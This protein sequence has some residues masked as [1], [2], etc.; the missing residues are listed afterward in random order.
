[1]QKMCIKMISWILPGMLLLNGCS[2]NGNLPDKAESYEETSQE[3][4]QEGTQQKGTP[5][6]GALPF[7]MNVDAETF[8]LSFLVEDQTVPISISAPGNASN[9]VSNSAPGNDS[10]ST[11]GAAPNRRVED[12]TEQEGVVS[13]RYPDE[14]IQVQLASKD[15]YLEVQITSEKSSDNT[16]VWPYI[17]ADQ[18]YLPLG[19]GKRV[20][21]DDPVWLNYLEQQQLSV[22]EQFSMPFW[23]TAQGEYCVLFIMEDP[24]RTDISFSAQPDLTFSVSHEYPAIDDNKTNTYRIY[25]TDQNPVSGA[26]I[27]R[28][29]VKE[30]G[31]FVTLK[32]KAEQNS[33]IE[34]LYGAPF[35]YLWGEFVISDDDVNWTAFR[36]AIDTPMMEYLRSFAADVENG[37]EFDSTL[38]ELKNQDYVAVYQ[39]NV[40]CSYISQVLQRDDFWNPDVFSASS[41]E[42]EELL[43][44]GYNS[45]NE[46]QKLQLHKYAL[47]SG[48]PDVFH[49]ASDWMNS[50]TLDLL[51][52]MQQAGIEHAWIGLN[53]WEQ[54]Y[55]KPELVEQ[56][57][58]AGYLIASYDS[59]HSIHAPGEEQWI[60]ARFEEP[61]LYENA[62]VTDKNGEKESGFQNVGR[63]LNP[64]LSMPSVKER[65][66]KIMS[67]QLPFNSWFIDCDATGEIYDDYTPEHITTQEQDLAARLERMAYIRDRYN[68]II[69]SEGGNDFASS[70]IAFA[71]GIE[72]K[73]FSWMDADMKSNKDSEYYIGKYYNPAGGAA[74]HFAKRI[75][76]KPQY[77]DV[78]VDPRY[79][80]PLFK[81]VYNDSVITAAHW[82]WS[83]FKIKGAT[84]D[85]MLREVLYN[86]PPIYHL[87]REM[88]S[89]YGQDMVSHHKVWSEFSRKAIQNEMTDFAYLRE[90]GTVQ[91]TVY[92][93]ELIAVANFGDDSFLYEGNEIAPHS[94]LIGES[95]KYTVYTPSLDEAHQ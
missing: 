83:T 42:M 91:K 47:S 73:S 22:M 68:L 8:E 54:A 84:Q 72:L 18:Y 14:H 7:T 36:Q 48:M 11:S 12:Y 58:D 75:P 59:Y 43:S 81:L 26:A 5:Q 49:E 13:W 16:F 6:K 74:E 24:Y 71:H 88:W 61:G 87:D 51:S 19:E 34:K 64:T 38:A 92:G 53:S 35:I 70:T 94:V 93:G 80:I 63:K 77:Y 79:D 86:V 55:V 33:D 17:A 44:N 67:S 82:D 28:N 66:D 3:A 30:K 89:E 10:N 27:Y 90:D 4:L 76:V 15:H 21:A 46:A 78:F 65:M 31:Q 23:I 32:Q 39:K 85:R 95:G 50:S 52:D 2:L 25:V 62:T 41:I 37:G 20:P 9:G 1:M 56:T 60:T 57:A 29:Y 45:L 69:G 40:I